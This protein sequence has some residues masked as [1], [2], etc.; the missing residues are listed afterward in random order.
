MNSLN[1]RRSKL[2]ENGWRTACNSPEMPADG[3]RAIENHW[4]Q[5]PCVARSKSKSRYCL[6]QLACAPELRSGTPAANARTRLGPGNSNRSRRSRT[7]GPPRRTFPTALHRP[8]SGRMKECR[9]PIRIARRRSRDA[10]PTPP[11]IAG[12]RREWIRFPHA[13]ADESTEDP[14]SATSVIIEQEWRAPKNLV[15]TADC[16][17]ISANSRVRF[18][19]SCSTLDSSSVPAK[20]ADS[21]AE[22]AGLQLLPQIP[23]GP[24]SKSLLHLQL[25]AAYCAV[26]LTAAWLLNLSA[27]QWRHSSDLSQQ[28]QLVSKAP[29]HAPQPRSVRDLPRQSFHPDVH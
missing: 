18:S 11:G 17:Q 10:R 26:P 7:R 1:C 13:E 8:P 2:Q 15:C 25:C 22:S 12:L 20:S 9:S 23:A 3:R 19:W 16:R 5:G 28:Q 27:I 6:S 21:P 29:L 4:P 14:A 24:K